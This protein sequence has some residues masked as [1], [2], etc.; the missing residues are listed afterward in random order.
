VLVLGDVAGSE[1]T[2]EGSDLVTVVELEESA[3]ARPPRRPRPSSLRWGAALTLGVLLLLLLLPS[4]DSQPRPVLAEGEVPP[5]TDG[6][7]LDWPGRGPWAADEQFVGEAI[8]AWRDTAREDPDVEPPGDEVVPLWAGPVADAQMTLLQSV[9]ADGVLRAA[10]VSDMLYGWLQ[11]RLRLLATTRVAGSPDF[12]VFPF[13]GPDDRRG[14]LDPDVLS[15][16]QML[17]SPDVRSGDLRVLRLE[18]TRVVPVELRDDGLSEPWAYGR[19]WIRDEPEIAVIVNGTDGSLDSVVRLDPD[20]LLPA[21]PPISLV[22]PRWGLDDPYRPEDYLA[23]AA[24]LASVGAPSGDVAVL[25]S[26]STAAGRVSLVHIEPGGL[27]RSRAVVV[28]TDDERTTVSAPVPMDPE[29]QVVI[30][31]ART[32]EGELLVAAAASPQTTLLTIDADSDVL[33]TGGRVLAT[34]VPRSAGVQVVGARAFTGDDSAAD[35]AEIAVGG[36]DAG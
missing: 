16:F 21:A 11:P 12:F 1:A 3:P 27:T 35:R 32:R 5:P 29:A 30:G 14:Q 25:G 20:R 18:G 28:L 2:T 4:D 26:T 7:L 24:A 15:T 36:V 13:V 17:P 22:E 10:Y 19:W 34:V 6:R 9:G 23:G 31:T 8:Q 33:A